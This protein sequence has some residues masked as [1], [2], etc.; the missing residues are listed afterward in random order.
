MINVI[1]LVIYCLI[2]SILHVTF[3]RHQNQLHTFLYTLRLNVCYLK[4]IRILHPH[5][6]AKIIGHILQNK[7]KSKCV[8]IHEIIRLIIMTMKIRMK[9]RSHRYSINRPRS[10]HGHKYSKHK[11]CLVMMML[12][13]I[14]K[15]L[16][17][18]WGSIYEKIKQHW[19]WVKKRRSLKKASTR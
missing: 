7:Q 17:N 14:K 18:I 5:Y 12:R 4:I 19:G 16:N 13:C 6:H 9:N 3:K 10:R 1:S 2:F 11:N 15:H 8:Y